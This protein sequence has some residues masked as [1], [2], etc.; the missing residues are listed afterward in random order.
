MT[1]SQTYESNRYLRKARQHKVALPKFH[2]TVSFYRERRQVYSPSLPLNWL[3]NLLLNEMI[4]QKRVQWNPFLQ[5]RFVPQKSNGQGGYT[6]LSFQDYPF[7]VLDFDG[8]SCEE[9]QRQFIE[10]RFWFTEKYPYSLSP[11]LSGAGCHLHVWVDFSDLPRDDYSASR[12]EGLDNWRH[13][14]RF[15]IYKD[16]QNWLC[17]E[18]ETHVGL[19]P[20]RNVIGSHLA[21]HPEEIG[22]INKFWGDKKPVDLPYFDLKELAT[23]STKTSYQLSLIK[24][25]D[26]FL[27]ELQDFLLICPYQEVAEWADKECGMTT[28]NADY[29]RQAMIFLR[30]NFTATK[31]HILANW[32]KVSV[33]SHKKE[34]ID[35]GVEDIQSRFFGVQN[36][37]YFTYIRRVFLYI[38]S[39][40]KTREHVYKRLVAQFKHNETAENK[41][42]F[43]S[44][45]LSKY[46]YRKKIAFATDVVQQVARDL[47]NGRTFERLKYWT[48]L[49]VSTFGFDKGLGLLYDGVDLSSA[50]DKN[51]R[52]KELLKFARRLESRFA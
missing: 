43:K 31:E 50:N 30:N 23:R 10:K 32:D 27:Q 12:E 9:A 26:P 3:P 36:S 25:L 37:M 34:R 8:I 6:I 4:K 17:D 52:K 11:S 2:S 47:G 5:S 48:P 42:F 21:Y 18:V 35:V 45:F 38:F 49:L 46:W 24:Q 41:S 29:Y 16:V 19:K 28:V 22:I 1:I 14:T 20:D 51:Q 7:V 13:G 39:L 33:F 15:R 40:T 44:S